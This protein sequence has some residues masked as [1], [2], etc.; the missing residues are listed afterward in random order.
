MLLTFNLTFLIL[1]KL[2]SFSSSFFQ[3]GHTAFESENFPNHFI[4]NKNWR[5][6]I[7]KLKNT[8]LFK[9]DSSFRVGKYLKIT[10]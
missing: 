8:D 5:L 4:R 10:F 2:L 6:R 1:T 9:K 3:K 7:D